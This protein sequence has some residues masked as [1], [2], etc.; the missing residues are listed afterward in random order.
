LWH[1]LILARSTRS[2]LLLEKGATAG[3]KNQFGN[4]ALLIAAE[5]GYPA[6]IR[7]LLKGGAD[8]NKE[9]NNKRQ[10]ALIIATEYNHMPCIDVSPCPQALVPR[11]RARL[12]D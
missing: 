6:V 3:S 9:R 7:L 2:Q 11:Q 10:T 8:A 5:N 4:T 12:D 1:N